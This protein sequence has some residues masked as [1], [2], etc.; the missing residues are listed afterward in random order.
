M[1]KI[2]KYMWQ[3]R[4][5]RGRERER[6]RE[7]TIRCFDVAVDGRYIG[8]SVQSIQCGI[9]RGERERESTPTRIV[10]RIF[11]LILVCERRK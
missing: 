3:T 1:T 6:E 10:N 9:E 7:A 4:R 8:H 11:F 5:E 2:E